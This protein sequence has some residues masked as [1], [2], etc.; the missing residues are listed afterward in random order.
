[1]KLLTE[2][3]EKDDNN[4]ETSKKIISYVSKLIRKDKDCGVDYKNIKE[5][6]KNLCKKS[7]NK[8]SLVNI[9]FECVE[10]YNS[11]VSSMISDLKYRNDCFIYKTKKENIKFDLN[12][13]KKLGY[14]LNKYPKKEYKA[15]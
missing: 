11:S 6:I 1:M 10:C 7:E 8:E 5:N 15:D 12:I 4:K 14:D 3:D 13:I 9:I 2:V